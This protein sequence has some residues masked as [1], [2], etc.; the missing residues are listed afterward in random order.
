ML[1]SAV[2]LGLVAAIGMA[3]LYQGTGGQDAVTYLQDSVPYIGADVPQGL[4]YGGDGIRVAVVDTGVDPTHP[5]LFGFGPDGKVRGRSFV[6][7]AEVPFDSNGHGTQVAGIIAANGGMQGIAPGSVIYSYK[8]SHDGDA[9]SS[10]L[11]V[12]A[13]RQAIA[14]DVDVINI[15]LGVNRTNR[16]ID[17][18]VN[19]ATR[20]GIVVVVAAGNDGPGAGTIG[21]PGIN[22]NAIT[23]G[24][25]HNNITSSLVATLE[26]DG[27]P[28]EVI[29]MVG[30]APLKSAISA[31]V[32]DGGYGRAADLESGGH[33][34]KIVLA[35]R[36]SDTE[37]EVV[38]FSDKE[39]NTANAGALA[40]LVYNNVEGLFL[41][42]LIHEFVDADYAPRIPTVS[43][44]R[45]DGLKIKDLLEDGAAGTL[46][47]FRNPD[48][49]AHF[50][51]R[52]PASPFYIKPDI[53]APGIFI[54]STSLGGG[55]NY[56]SGTS[57]ATPHVSGAVALLLEKN[58]TLGPSEIKSIIVTTTDLA[59][60]E[61]GEQFPVEV[62][63][64]GRLNVTR[65]FNA[66]LIIFPT[67]LAFD[68]ALPGTADTE[69]L[70]VRTTD[71]PVGDIG[72]RIS[73]PDAFDVS[74]ETSGDGVAF[75]ARMVQ[76]VSGEFA[77]RIFLTHKAT[78]YSIPFVIRTSEG[79]V[80]ASSDSGTLSL[81]VDAPGW[82][83]ARIYVTD[84]KTGYTDAVSAVPGRDGQLRVYDP[85]TYW[86]E[87]R[88]TAGDRTYSI[89]D[90]IGVTQA[91]ER[92]ATDVLDI[93][94]PYRQMIILAGVTAAVAASGV[95]LSRYRSDSPAAGSSS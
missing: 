72:V 34:G 12:K 88:V 26:V 55:Y 41:G 16:Q 27:K 46:H 75:T 58:P 1:R 69:A 28:F 87:A 92:G 68:I 44:S 5:D 18:A 20:E 73:A 42:E 3:L 86:I 80:T 81:G 53:V 43:M 50:S 30:A 85:G 25:T 78:E 39:F 23:V 31:Q 89:Y 67:S 91:A 93:G 36:G 74:H 52:G 65:A 21:S 33:E 40:L 62:A 22:P 84:S 66:E 37:G 2:L 47:I 59:S 38:Y 8:V 79:A 61:H 32:V 77:G 14:D 70:R 95:A 51:S 24:A 94:L 63:G 56:T 48:F 64:S 90:K 17:E 35:E 71:P 60:D 49:V 19:E 57:F 29:P 76:G 54:N 4:G 13:V 83:F 15:S 10:D 7:Q 45:E 6:G 82:S 9:V 11:I